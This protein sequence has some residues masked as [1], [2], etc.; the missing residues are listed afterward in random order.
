M[1]GAKSNPGAQAPKGGKSSPNP[2]EV[3]NLDTSHNPS[4]IITM[5]STPHTSTY[6]IYV[7]LQLT[8]CMLFLFLFFPF[9]IMVAKALPTML[10]QSH[11]HW[12]VSDLFYGPI[13]G[14]CFIAR[15][16]IRPHYTTLVLYGHDYNHLQCILVESQ[17]I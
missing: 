1:T 10:T 7:L 11:C 6:F 17:V 5:S 13:G 2:L 12:K 15:M 9:V 3:P 4:G 8:Q 16:S 14:A